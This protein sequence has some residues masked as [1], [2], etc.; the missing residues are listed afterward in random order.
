[1]LTRGACASA[2]RGERPSEAPAASLAAVGA[3]FLVDRIQVQ[4]VIGVSNGMDLDWSPLHLVHLEPTHPVLPPI[5]TEMPTRN[6]ALAVA[7]RGGTG[8]ITTGLAWP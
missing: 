5:D 7:I 2:L 3:I 4:K 6:E 1:L 8:A